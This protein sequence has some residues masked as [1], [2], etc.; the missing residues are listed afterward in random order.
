[1]SNK[2]DKYLDDEQVKKNIELFKNDRE[3]FMNDSEYLDNIG[4]SYKN[5]KISDDSKDRYKGVDKTINY[6]KKKD[7]VVLKKKRYILNLVILTILVIIVFFIVFLF[8]YKY[9]LKDDFI[10]K[11]G[12]SNLFSGVSGFENYF[13]IIGI[14]FYIYVFRGIIVFPIIISLVIWII[15]ILFTLYKRRRSHH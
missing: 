6:D 15:Y 3:N 14:M 2:K 12:P 7:M 4:V 8:K 5:N 13:F 10:L 11:N 1:M 9:F